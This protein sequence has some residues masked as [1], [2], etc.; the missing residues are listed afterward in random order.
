MQDIL[1]NLGHHPVSCN[2]QSYYK[3]L[4]NKEDGNLN[5]CPILYDPNPMEA[6]P[7][8]PK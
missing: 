1:V 3:N 6:Y 2:V 5:S 8:D 7:N 4:L